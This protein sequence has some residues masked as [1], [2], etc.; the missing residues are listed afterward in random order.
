MKFIKQNLNLIITLIH[1]VLG[2]YVLYM[3]G[4]DLIW[5]SLLSY[6]IIWVILQPCWW[7]F[8]LW[9][10]GL[11]KTSNF[12]HNIHIF[13]YC[14]F[15]PFKPSAPMLVHLKHHKVFNTEADRNTF[16]VNQGRI[17]HLF[18]MTS[19][20]IRTNTK[21]F[22]KINFPESLTFWNLAEKH[23]LKIFIITNIL[24]LI[25]LNKYYILCHSIPYIIGRAELVVKIHDMV[26][27]YKYEKN[28]K[29]KPI[30][31]LLSFCDAWHKDHHEEK[32]I[33][34]FGPKLYKWLN[35]Q[36]YYF[37][38]ID[39]RIRSRCL[40]TKQHIIMYE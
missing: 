3:Y 21:R 31:F 28:F 6:Y 36:F 39:K 26:W 24:L 12:V 27:H 29:N 22:V 13:L 20:P 17:K 4:L 5:I 35:P 2:I 37:C 8:S 9:H 14:V 19:P 7:H 11:I 1:T 16:K 33:L 34:N 10:F 32:M 15:F 30:M 40:F 38:I 25:L 18:N 23:H